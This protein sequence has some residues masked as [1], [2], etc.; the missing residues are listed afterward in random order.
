[1]LLR[2]SVAK[3]KAMPR[4]HSAKAKRLLVRGA[5]PRPGLMHL[6]CIWNSNFPLFTRYAAMNN[7]RDWKLFPLLGF[8]MTLRGLQIKF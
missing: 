2:A 8:L 5:R 1:M 7:C 4:T 3:R 6:N